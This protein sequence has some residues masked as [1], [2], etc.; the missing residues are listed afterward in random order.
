MT[1]QTTA[2]A[3]SIN[4]VVV[5]SALDARFGDKG[6][7]MQLIRA[8]K[9]GDAEKLRGLIA[10]GVAVDSIDENGWTPLAW[11]VKN[12]HSD[13]ARVL[14]DAGAN[15]EHESRNGWT[16]MALAV[17]S[18]SPVIIAVTMGGLDRKVIPFPR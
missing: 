5:A 15:A 11:A 12:R 9:T 3:A 14:I 2:T 18:G 7:G 4:P 1:A 16:P 13:I 10:A 17:K 6:A 8:A